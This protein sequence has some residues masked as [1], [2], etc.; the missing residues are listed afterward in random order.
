MRIK[1]EKAQK[2]LST[3]A[4][5]S[6]MAIT[7]GVTAGANKERRDFPEVQARVARKECLRE[8]D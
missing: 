4:R 7:T 5:M 1:R 2:A 8:K 3:D 6:I